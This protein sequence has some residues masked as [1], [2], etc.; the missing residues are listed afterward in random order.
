[1]VHW[2]RGNYV[3]NAPRNLLVDLLFTF[4]TGIVWW[5]EVVDQRNK[6]KKRN[7]R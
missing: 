5:Q 1:M 3:Y 2:L 7:S 4:G 6:G